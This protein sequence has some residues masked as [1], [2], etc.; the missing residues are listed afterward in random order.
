M[1]AV[2]RALLFLRRE[3]RE[4]LRQ[5]SVD[6]VRIVLADDESDLEALL[7]PRERENGQPVAS[8]AY[9]RVELDH[10]RPLV[11]RHESDEILMVSAYDMAHFRYSR[12]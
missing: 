8:L 10:A 7:R 3:R 4:E 5:H 12:G 6:A 9:H 1:Q 2:N 11:L